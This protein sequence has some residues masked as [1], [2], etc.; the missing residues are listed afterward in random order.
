[1]V[2]FNNSTGLK[3]IDYILADVNTIKNEE[4]DYIT[5]IYKLPQFGILIVFR[6]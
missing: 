4:K 3:E 5:K 6:I 2:E 1:M